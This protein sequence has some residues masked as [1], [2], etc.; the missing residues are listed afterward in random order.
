MRVCREREVPVPEAKVM[1]EE[2]RVDPVALL[3]WSVVVVRV[4]P[5]AL[6]NE[7]LGTAIEAERVRAPPLALMKLR[8]VKEARGQIMDVNAVSVEHVADPLTTR[9]LP[10]PC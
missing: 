4:V 7:T 6:E 8:V 3:N 5:T 9:V 10:V 1:V 2:V